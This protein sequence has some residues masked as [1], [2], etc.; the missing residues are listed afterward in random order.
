MY[1]ENVGGA[2][3]D[4]VLP[5]LNLHARVPLCGMIAH[6]NDRALPP[7]PDRLPL[8]QSVVLQKRI[9][10]QGFI[11]ADHYANRF[12]AFRHDM[13]HW[14]S[15]KQIVLTENIVDGLQS[16]PAAFID[17]L[18]GRHFGK[19]VIRLVSDHVIHNHPEQFACT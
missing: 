9:H 1:F 12:D 2:V 5:L 11:I 15:G 3:F 16:A 4:A 7:G 8:L 17:M 10:M 18:E 13:G 19:L 14:V 6:Y